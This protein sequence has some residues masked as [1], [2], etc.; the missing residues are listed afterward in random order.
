MSKRTII[1]ALLLWISGISVRASEVPYTSMEGIDS[2]SASYFR[3]WYHRADLLYYLEAWNDHS[4]VEVPVVG[5]WWQAD[6]LTFAIDGMSCYSNRYYIDGM[7]ADDRFQPGNTVYVPNMQR[8]DLLVDCHN[9][10][11]YFSRDMTSGNYAQVSYNFGQVG[12][13][14]PA[15]GTKEIINISHRSA[16]ESADVFKHITDRRHLAGAGTIDAAYSFK[17][18]N[19]EKYRQHLYAAFGQRVLTKEDHC[20]LMLDDPIYKSNYYKVQADGRLPMAANRVFSE[21]NYRMNFSG[22]EDG[23][24]EYLYNWNE[25]YDLKNYTGTIYAKR[26][27][28]TTGL[29]WATNVVKHSDQEFRKNILDQDGESFAPWI[30]D[31]KTHELSWAV[32]YEQPVLDWLS[33]HVDAYNSFLSFR[34]TQTTYANVVYMQSPIAAMPT[35]LYRYEWSSHAF[36]GGLLENTIGLKAHYS[37]CKQLD[38][39]GFVDFTLDGMLL[40]GK[41]KVSPNWQAGVNLDLHPCR[42]FKMGLTVSHE[43]VPYTADYLR[44]FSDDYM[45]ANIY[46]VGTNNLFATTGGKYHSY[47]KRLHQTSFM[48]VNIPIHFQ[49]GRHEIVLQNSY[50]KFFNVWHTYYAGGAD[51]NGYYKQEGDVNVFYL[52][53]GEKF[54]EV[55][56]TEPFGTNGLLNSPYFFSQLT[57]YTYTGRKVTVGISWQSMQAA[58]YTGIGNGPNSNTIGVLSETTANPNTTNVVTNPGAKYPGVSRMDLDKGYVCRFYLGYNICKWVQAGLTVKW[59][60]GKPFTS[61]NYYTD[62]QQIAILPTSSRGTN[63]TDGNFGTR[64]GA[65]YNVDLHVQGKWAVRDVEM[66]L[67]LECY[68]M[69]DFCNDLAE[70]AFDQDIPYATRA[71]MTMSVPTGILVNYTIDF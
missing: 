53:G 43:R 20:G 38:I 42:W 58:G 12:N 55:G 19:G 15:L 51:V 26:Q 9:A 57:R 21:L 66:C 25:V 32:N 27:Y 18:T 41:S 28:L 22:K 59:T 16:M 49:F 63:P 8:Y 44:Y 39:N 4:I 54:Y 36:A 29:T 60:D 1:F 30:A 33:V 6:R 48:E 67:S 47:S 13:G 69:W 7:R 35:D 40:R 45:N 2:V 52:N 46:Y 65:W 10:S 24:S 68:N 31:G 37:L 62:G 17:G 70:L 71:S 50:K 3:T 34:P 56:Y 11:L 5:Q 61:Y 64:H 14:Q 23:G